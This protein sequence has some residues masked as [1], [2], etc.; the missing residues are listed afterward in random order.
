MTLDN[1]EITLKINITGVT[2]LCTKICENPA[3]LSYLT[4]DYHHDLQ[5][6][7]VCVLYIKFNEHPP[8][9]THLTSAIDKTCFST[10]I[11]ILWWKNHISFTNK[12]N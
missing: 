5:E 12:Q 2:V 11:M 6:K 8:I 9:F 1:F 4:P 10:I 7:L 3:I